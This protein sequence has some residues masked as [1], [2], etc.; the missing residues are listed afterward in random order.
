VK[1]RVFSGLMI[2]KIFRKIFWCNFDHLGKNMLLSLLWILLHLPVFLCIAFLVVTKS[3]TFSFYII[4]VNFLAL[5]PVTAGMFYASLPMV[6]SEGR[7]NAPARLFQG[8]RKFWWRSL[9]LFVLSTL[10]VLVASNAL[11][12]YLKES[13][14]IN[15][16]LRVILAGLAFWVLTYVLFMQLSFFPLLVRLETKVAQTLYKSF[17]L[18]LG[19]PGQHILFGLFFFFSFVIAAFS[20]LG[21][22]LLWPA[23]YALSVNIFSLGL[24]SKYNETIVFEQETRTFRHL[25][26]PWEP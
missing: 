25:F 11:V 14:K 8:I 16:F 21:F 9:L 15:I 22:V 24:L 1:E 12:F 18:V 3:H 23:Y 17:L 26:K 20:I 4:L 6:N 19:N 13:L 7:I 2:P 5:S 10:L